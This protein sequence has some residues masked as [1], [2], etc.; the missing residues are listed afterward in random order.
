[1]KI[2]TNLGLKLQ[3]Y[4]QRQ[5]NKVIFQNG[6]TLNQLANKMW[7][8]LGYQGVDAS[9]LSRVIHGQRLF[10]TKQL[11]IFCAIL[12]LKKQEQD[13]LYR[14]LE[15]DYLDRHKLTIFSSRYNPLD[16]VDI[17][18][19][20]L[21]KI[22]D[23]RE[24]GLLQ[25]AIDWADELSFQLDIYCHNAK[26]PIIKDKMF[27]LLGEMLFQKGYASGA[28]LCPREN[29]QN[30]SSLVKKQLAIAKITHSP[31]LATKAYIT[32][33]FA[34]YLLGNYSRKHCYLKFYKKS[35]SISQ[36]SLSLPEIPDEL[37][38]F[39]LRYLG[40]NTIYLSDSNGFMLSLKEIKKIIRRHPDASHFDYGFWALD[41]IARGQAYFDRS[42]V[43]HTLEESRIFNQNLV[44][45]DPLKEA[46]SIKTEL[47]ILKQLQSQA[48][49]YL[50][51][52]R[53]KGLTIATKYGFDRYRRYF[54]NQL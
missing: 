28:M 48:G 44:R 49:N 12:E 53:Q 51:R 22:D 52:Q 43:L 27:N 9:V 35:L 6:L 54:L 29:M 14:T 25:T 33:A 19:S 24:R 47:E 46:A 42:K 30:N 37:R 41:T 15:I 13:E 31:Q 4:Y 21:A 23:V 1:M 34:Y 18:S 39:F 3:S 50:Q 40:L 32:K 20:Q 2:K 45:F 36:K 26:N 10:T 17:F 7:E 5:N 38:L 8:R 11:E 16:I